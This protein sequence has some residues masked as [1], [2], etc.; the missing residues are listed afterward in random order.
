MFQVSK[1]TAMMSSLS[2][3]PGAG[4]RGAAIPVSGNQ[5]GNGHAGGF[6]A[7]GGGSKGGGGGGCKRGGAAST[8]A[9]CLTE[10]SAAVAMGGANRLLG[11][12]EL[13][14]HDRQSN[15]CLYASLSSTQV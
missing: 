3:S 10:T 15:S 12:P 8:A 14:S 11:T 13:K 1:T 4:Y 7:A 9:S 2:V 5:A 6:V